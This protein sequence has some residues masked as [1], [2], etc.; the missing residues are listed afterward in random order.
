MASEPDEV[1]ALL[2]PDWL[3]HHLAISGSLGALIRFRQAA[4]GPGVI[5]WV[6][7]HARLEEDLFLS[8]MREDTGRPRELSAV[9]AHVL[10]ARLRQVVQRLDASAAIDPGSLPNC[11]FDLQALLPV[12]AA[13]LDMGPDQPRARQWLWSSWGTT[14]PLR[15]VS[16]I[17]PEPGQTAPAAGAAALRLQFWSADWTPWPAI[18]QLRLAWPELHF[19]IRPLYEV[20]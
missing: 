2:Q 16:E 10:A 7:D 6:S 5:P 3:F 9:G 11:L 4:A 17:L 15:D 20:G 1:L 14:R 19:T 8:L 18:Q 12:P 13:V